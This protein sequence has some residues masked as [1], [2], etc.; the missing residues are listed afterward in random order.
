MALKAFVPETKTSFETKGYG[1]CHETYLCQNIRRVTGCRTLIFPSW[2]VSV[3]AEREATSRAP[4]CRAF[5]YR[6]EV[7]PVFK[8]KWTEFDFAAE[9]IFYLKVLNFSSR[10]VRADASLSDVGERVGR[11]RRRSTSLSPSCSPGRRSSGSRSGGGGK[12]GRCS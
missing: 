10:T 4:T 11:R 9:F 3:E 7:F 2:T 1:A 6:S 5:Q 12:R 8:V